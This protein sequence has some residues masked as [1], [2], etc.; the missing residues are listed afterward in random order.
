MTADRSTYVD[1]PR[2]LGDIAYLL[3]E[4]EPNLPNSRKP[5]SEVKLAK[6]VG[7]SRGKLQNILSGTKV[8]Y[9]DGCA[10]IARWSGLCGKPKEFAPITVRSM[11]ASTMKERA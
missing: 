6:A 8:E 10:L 1:W 9:H 11:S 4:D 2:L 7:F 5:L 3:G